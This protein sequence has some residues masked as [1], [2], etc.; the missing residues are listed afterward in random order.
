M[1]TALGGIDLGYRIVVLKD[2]VCSSA[3]E[4]YD[5]SIKLLGDRFSVQMMLISTEQF[6][7]RAG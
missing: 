3:D 2:A 4:T 1:A 5:A 6:L 7:A